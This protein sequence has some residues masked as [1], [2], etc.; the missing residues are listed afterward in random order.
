MMAIGRVLKRTRKKAFSNRKNPLPKELSFL[1]RIPFYA[2][3]KCTLPESDTHQ[4]R[5]ELLPASLKKI[6]ESH[7]KYLQLREAH[8]D[9]EVKFE[10]SKVL[11]GE[12]QEYIESLEKANNQLMKNLGEGP[13][14]PKTLLRSYLQIAEEIGF[15]VRGEVQGGLPSLGKR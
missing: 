1:S 14:T 13:D 8:G 9:L 10:R 3:T 2:V 4:T 7:V 11:F 6:A 15:I 12:Q 5:V